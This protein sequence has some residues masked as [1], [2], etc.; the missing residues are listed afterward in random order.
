MKVVEFAGPFKRF[1][2]GYATKMSLLHHGL[3]IA[4]NDAAAVKRWMSELAA[5][6]KIASFAPG[7]HDRMAVS[8]LFRIP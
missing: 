5:E 4:G 7:L 8:H 1:M 2:G 3:A 6:R